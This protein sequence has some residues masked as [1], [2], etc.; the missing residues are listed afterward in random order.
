MTNELVRLLAGHGHGTDG[1]AAIQAFLGEK[2]LTDRLDWLAEHLLPPA[3]AHADAQARVDA[4][5]EPFRVLQG[6]LIRSSSA[7]KLGVRIDGDPTYV[8]ATS[9]C[10]L[11]EGRRSTALL[12]PV[13]ARTRA[14]FAS[15]RDLT[16]TLETLT[17]YRPKKHFCLPVLPDDG[18]DVVCNV[19]LLDPLHVIA[20]R[21]RFVISRGHGLGRCGAAWND[22][23]ARERGA[24]WRGLGRCA[25]ARGR[26]AANLERSAA[27]RPS[28]RPRTL[29]ADTRRAAADSDPSQA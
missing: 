24:R 2:L 29:M 12:L 6:D 21:T 15:D 28:M 14:D 20:N 5:V 19:A 7:Y 1:V 16:A 18:H 8:I 25:A 22:V 11:V 26:S 13:V 9:S 23:A 27:T 17:A 10:D 4:P 3:L